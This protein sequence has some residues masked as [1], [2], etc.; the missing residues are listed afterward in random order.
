MVCST[1]SEYSVETVDLKSVTDECILI[2]HWSVGKLRHVA[3]IPQKSGIAVSFRVLQLTSICLFLVLPSH[4]AQVPS[5]I[6]PID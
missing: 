5:F 1:H 6:P 3:F 2:A 4:Q